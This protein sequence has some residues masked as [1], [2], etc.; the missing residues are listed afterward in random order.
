M[1][2]STSSEMC[3]KKKERKKRRER[4][5]KRERE[6]ERERESLQDIYGIMIETN[7]YAH[8]KI[9]TLYIDQHNFIIKINICITTIQVLFITNSG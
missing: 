2:Q 5:R 4:E 9:Y 6:R 7:V 8:C 3:H 1:Y